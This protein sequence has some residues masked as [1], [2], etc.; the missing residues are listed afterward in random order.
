MAKDRKEKNKLNGK[1]KQYI[2]PTRLWHD[3]E[4]PP[5]SNNSNNSNSSPSKKLSDDQISI[6]FELA[7]ELLKTENDKYTTNSS[8][9]S[10]S[11]RNFYATMLKSGTMKD[12]LSTLSVLVDESPLHAVQ[13]L[14]T[15]MGTAKKKSRNIS[16]QAIENIM[17]LMLDS[18][19][20]NRKLKYF[21]DQ[22]L[23]DPK[24]T[25]EHLIVWAFEDFIKNYYYDFIRVI[26]ML[27]HDVLMH[28]RQKTIM[29]I[30]TLFKEKPEQEQ[31]L[32]KLLVNKLGDK[33]RKVTS[34]ASYLI[35]QIFMVHPL[36]KF[37]IVREIEQL[38]LLPNA[39][40]RSQYYGIITLNQIILSKQDAKVANK[41]ID[42]YFVLFTKLLELKDKEIKKD[43]NNKKDFTKSRFKITKSRSRIKSKSKKKVNNKIEIDDAANSKLVA[44]LLTGVN[45]AYKFTQVDH[46]VF[47]THLN[48]LYRIT[49]IGTF[50][51][52][53]QA[54]MLIY[55][56]SFNKESL[57]DRFYRALYQSLLDPRLV[58]SSKHAMYLNLLF[59]SLKNDSLIVRTEAFIKR[60]IQICGHHFPPFICGALYLI[61]ALVQKHP[62]LHHFITKSEDHDDNSSEEN[63][64]KY[65][66][67]KRD[68][69]YSH[70]DRSSLWELSI[71]ANHFHPT[72][73][74][75]AKQ[76]L[77]N[78][79]IETQPEL[80]NHTLSHFLDRFVYRN[81]KKRDRIKGGGNVLLQPTIATEPG[82]VIMKRSTGIS[83]DEINVN[84]K[85]FWG[86]KLEDIPVDQVFFHKYFTQ[87]QSSEKNEKN[88]KSKKKKKKRTDDIDNF[89]DQEDEDEEKEIWKAMKA[90]LPIKLDSDLDDDDE[91]SEDDLENLD[92]S[93]DDE[94]EVYEEKGEGDEIDEE[95]EGE[96]EDED[97]DEDEKM[98]MEDDDDE[99]EEE[100]EEEEDEGVT[101]GDD[102]DGFDF[103][104]DE[105]DII[106]S[107]DD[108]KRI[109]KKVKLKHL[110]TFAS[111]EDIAALIH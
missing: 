32:L 15:L 28:V 101:T 24:V 7:K 64:Q 36:M 35:N 99:E 47:E 110:P 56:V 25:N 108:D 57:S 89:I 78:K 37:H 41:L 34:K 59:K 60:L 11:D 19:L 48:I 88:E 104:E 95:E 42:I 111:Y 4:L 92:F 96:D 107:S 22:P 49:Y 87:K 98:E 74:L 65:D 26:E 20:P 75:Y 6:K 82:M 39:N 100:E 43:K 61:S 29:I 94:E 52:S 77:E 85:E 38:I 17:N 80:H 76:I 91:D 93:S 84:S 67:R 66:G 73:S 105:K 31:N 68:P 70:A 27:S 62:S 69:Q 5:L 46:S 55:Q 53:I 23:N 63:S 1:S 81:P 13:A 103:M 72:I 40:E 3:I 106:S 102:N 10:A 9:H 45:R 16:M 2:N 90:T 97:E 33:E 79:S 30:F 12:K 109:R 8:T 54:L 58:T 51:I 21:R 14:E 44:A 18:I 71:F 83:P 86:K 50:N